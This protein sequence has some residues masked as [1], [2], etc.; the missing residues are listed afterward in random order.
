MNVLSMKM[1][2]INFAA[3]Q[4]SRMVDINVSISIIYY[5]P[6]L[7]IWKNMCKREDGLINKFKKKKEVNL[8]N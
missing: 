1:L 8:R 6:H 3:M 5:I 4:I 2:N 7:L